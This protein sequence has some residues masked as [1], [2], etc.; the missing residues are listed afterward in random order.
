MD[1]NLPS[2]VRAYI[3][4]QAENDV[5]YKTIVQNVESTYGRTI[6]RGTISK[7]RDKFEE[8]KTVE[9]LPRSGRPRIFGSEEE[10]AIVTAV[11]EDPK[12][13]ATDVFIDGDLN[14]A[15]A[16]LRTIQYLL[17]KNG[18]EATTT[19]PTQLTPERIQK[20]LDFAEE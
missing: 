2:H 8:F 15:N 19:Q 17:N 18:L 12:M 3:L 14:K 10:Q 7:I 5:A 1:S 6:S 20:R 11:E 4:G 13:T 9:E 16:S